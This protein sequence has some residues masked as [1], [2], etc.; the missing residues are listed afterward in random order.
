M[1]LLFNFICWFVSLCLFHN[2]FT[3]CSL[4]LSMGFPLFAF[5]LVIQLF[6]KSLINIWHFYGIFS[7][8]FVTNVTNCR[9]RTKNADI[10]KKTYASMYVHILKWFYLLN[11][12]LQAFHYLIE[13]NTA[14]LIY[15]TVT[16]KQKIVF[17]KIS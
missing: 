1:L 13:G 4:R 17:L 11:Q 9:G 8:F 15:A 3:Q 7:Y 16:A 14:Q 2:A 12:P 5:F 6:Q 10:K